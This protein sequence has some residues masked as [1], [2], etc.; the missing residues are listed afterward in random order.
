MHE[1][2]FYAQYSSRLSKIISKSKSQ[3]TSCEFGESEWIF[4]WRQ[5]KGAYI[6]RLFILQN[7]L[8][9]SW[10]NLVKK[11][12]ASKIL[13][14]CIGEKRLQNLNHQVWGASQMM[15]VCEM[16]II[17]TTKWYDANE[18]HLKMVFSCASNSC[19]AIWWLLEDP[20]LAC[21]ESKESCTLLELTTWLPLAK[22]QGPAV[23][24]S[25]VDVL[26]PRSFDSSRCIQES[27]YTWGQ[28]CCFVEDTR[29]LL[30]HT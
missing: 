30:S 16:A 10:E 12:R 18:D 15:R 25:L 21:H 13:D 5:Q 27:E 8:F 2:I 1:F 11:M 22:D 4:Y 24:P 29:P 9:N 26:W 3:E 7:V 17:I 6:S 20:S 14:S 19:Q 28:K 23:S